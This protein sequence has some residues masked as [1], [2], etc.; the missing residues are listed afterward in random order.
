MQARIVSG[1]QGGQWL[2]DGWR[3]FRA[4]PL[5]WLA[6]VFAYWFLMTVASLV[7]FLGIV[8]ASALVPAFSVGF[9][10]AARAAS[11]G[12]PVELSL[13]FDGFR[14]DRRAM[15]LLG[16][17]YF[18]CL[19]FVLAG[20][21]LADNGALAR[22]M[23]SGARPDEAVLQ[24]DAFVGALALA[25][26][27]Y[28]PVMAAFWFAPPLAAWHST[29]AA[30]ALFFSFVGCLLNWRP[31]LVYGA[32]TALVTLVIPMVLLMALMLG[33]GDA[34]KVPVAGLAFPLLLMILPILFASFYASYRDV[35]GQMSGQ[36]NGQMSGQP[37]RS[38]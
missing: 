5:G 7:P 4:A 6:L 34:G 29:G 25:S 33:L 30:K 2:I 10:A 20:S 14:H 23:L 38:K 16:L 3:M 9:M 26:L 31:F 32:V 11:R 15:V 19:A 24:S 22:W 27:L 28:V 37:D 13:L 21:A 12:A 35:F 8:L 18:A 17:A 1:A 36:M